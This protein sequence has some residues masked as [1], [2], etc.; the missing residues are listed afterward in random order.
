[1]IVRRDFNVIVSEEENVEGLPFIYHEE[2]K[3]FHFA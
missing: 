3:F 1:M 2:N